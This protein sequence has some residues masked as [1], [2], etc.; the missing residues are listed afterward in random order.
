MQQPYK[1]KRRTRKDMFTLGGWLFA[2]LLLGLAMLFAVANTV[3]Q[4]P[5]TPTPTATPNLLATAESDLALSQAAN[6]QTVEALQ[7]E[8]DSSST[9]AQQ[10]QAAADDLFAAATQQ[11]NDEATRAAMNADER[12]TAD[13]QSTQ[14]A[15]VAQAT[16]DALATQQAGSEQ[17]AASLNNELATSVAQATEA[18]ASANDLAT[19]Q[20][21]VAAIATENADSGANALATSAAAQ[22]ALATSEAA[23]AIAQATADAS[24]DEVAN[25]QA[26]VAASSAEV[27]NAQA[28]AAAADQAVAD[29]QATSAAAQEQV[30]LNALDPNFVPVIIQVDL[31]G[32][33]QGDADAIAEAEDELQRVLGP[34]EES[35]NCRVGFANITSRSNQLGE[36]VQLSDAIATLIED[37]HPDLLQDTGDGSEKQLVSVSIA[38]PG[39]APVGEVEMQL[40]LNAGCAPAG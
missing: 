15:E 7:A 6:Q 30:E 24:G 12:A 34:Y 13:A 19:Q 39:T 32:V 21:E 8:I 28:T 27:A 1:R 4:A 22:D 14:Q 26:T 29:A 11:A 2:D 20:A 23:A 3:G 35:G 40:F 9:S 36:G 25:A 17:D 5:P 31:A 33:L 16:I 38:R 18:A 10:T 37:N